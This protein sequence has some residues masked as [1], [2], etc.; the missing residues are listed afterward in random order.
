M[1]AKSMS[2]DEAY[3]RS[4]ER[5]KILAEALLDYANPE[6]WKHTKIPTGVYY[7]GRPQT[8]NASYYNGP[9][10]WE[11]ALMALSVA[12]GRPMVAGDLIS[13]ILDL[14]KEPT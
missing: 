8:R 7:N 9:K 3:R 13:D 12:K 6:N 11:I 14:Y 2:W 5:N 10:P 1:T 4:E